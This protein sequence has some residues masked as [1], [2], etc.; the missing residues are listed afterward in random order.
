MSN[1]ADDAKFA[2]ESS[3]LP[4][5][6][7]GIFVGKVA[8]LGPS[9]VPSA[10]VKHS[11][12]GAAYAEALG[13]VGDMQ[14]DLSVHGGPDKAVYAYPCDNYEAWKAEFP[15]LVPLWVAGSLGENL[16]LAGCDERDVC[17]GDTV[18]LGSALLQVSQPRKP[19]FKMAIRFNDVRL[20]KAMVVSGRCGWYYR[21]VEPGSFTAGDRPVLVERPHPEW[22]IRRINAVTNSTST[23]QAAL[24]ELAALPELSAAW[25]NQVLAA[26]QAAQAGALRKVFRPFSVADVR[27]ESRTIRSFVLKP[28]DGEG[29]A[30]HAPG[31]HV[32]V[33][34]PIHGKVAPRL[35]SYS[36]STTSNGK[37][38]QISV[39]RDSDYGA[40]AWMHTNLK[41]GSELDVMGPR[42]NFVL[43][44]TS[45]APILLLSAGVG[46]TPIMAMLIA[47][48]TNNGTSVM[49]RRVTF[50]HGARNGE[51]LAFAGLLSEIAAKHPA[52]VFHTRFSAPLISDVAGHNHDSVGRL[53][54]AL[55]EKIAEDISDHMVYLCGPA[56]FMRTAIG[57][58]QELGVP[59][60]QI[61]CENFGDARVVANADGCRPARIVFSRSG[62][63]S[64]WVRGNQS[65]LQIAEAHGI[66]VK[67][68]CRVGLCGQC[69]T[70]VIAGEL[71]YATEPAAHIEYG[72]ALLCCA[73]PASPTVT[74]DL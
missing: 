43:D 14:A 29:V 54:K 26:I 2:F 55:V 37:T 30:A 32:V 66:S 34:L 4:V 35:R 56:S 8:P 3:A 44:Q 20:P 24:A 15:N 40:S 22:T 25:R 61:R 68:D 73:R 42:G 19:C 45:D 31:Q 70:P 7:V 6:L 5:R 11:V 50:I 62:I 65:L 71:T 74:L 53:D 63:S 57:W 16:A 49:P 10:F 67:N 48:T 27:D 9:G 69:A 39:K 13:L 59:E 1:I 52:V 47:A 72:T 60:A 41:P 46:I 21:V 58:L 17:V 38:Y 23:P 33:R 18:R 64:Q 51:E 28:V 36:L 12:D